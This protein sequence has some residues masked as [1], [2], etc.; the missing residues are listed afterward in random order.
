MVDPSLL[1]LARA[2]R[3]ALEPVLVGHDDA[4][5]GLV[6]ALLARE[7][8]YLEGP[9]GCGKSALATAFARIA[10][11]RVMQASFHRDTNATELLGTPRLRRERRGNA[12][13]LAF[14]LLPGPL[15]GAEVLLL[16]DLSR[17]PG[18]ALA[19]LL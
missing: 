16:D 11:A 17:A 14:E 12:E 1:Q 6:L 13:R 10:G 3:D 8:A 4:K 15:A 7:H 5:T 19:P 9:P 2:T 18:E